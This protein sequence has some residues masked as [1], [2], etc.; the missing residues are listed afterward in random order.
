M[1]PA[2]ITKEYVLGEIAKLQYLYTLKNEIRYAQRRTSGETE[3]VAEH[4]F[5]MHLVAQ[6]F[7]PLLDAAG[8]WNRTHI[9]EMITLHDIDEIET[10]DVLGY[11]KSQADRDS[12]GDVMRKVIEKSPLHMQERMRTR[13]NEYEAQETIESRFARAV[14]KFEPL[15]QIYNETGKGILHSNGTT[16]AQS[17][18]IKEPFLIHFP[19]MYAYYQIIQQAMIDEGYFS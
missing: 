1:Q 6:Y 9:Y 16:A 7:L 15:V 2:E 10:G 17:A 13:V 8:E 14:D 4:I 19:L 11:T 18:S 3:S 12:E 5:G